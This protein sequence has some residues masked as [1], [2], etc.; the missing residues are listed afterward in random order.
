LVPTSSVRFR[1][2]DPLD[3]SN[4]RI[5]LEQIG[6][7]AAMLVDPEDGSC[8]VTFTSH[9]TAQR[10]VDQG[11]DFGIDDVKFTSDADIE[12]RS[13]ELD[14]LPEHTQIANVVQKR[15]RKTVAEPRIFWVPAADAHDL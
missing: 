10:L 12:R 14:I 5:R 9:E 1:L 7:I 4:L 8:I 13:R 6:Q 11:R 15:F 2:P 3:I